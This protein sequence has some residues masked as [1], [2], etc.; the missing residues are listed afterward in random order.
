[1]HTIS[2]F[3]TSCQVICSLKQTH[4][5]SL[6]ETLTKAK[7]HFF[8]NSRGHWTNLY[9]TAGSDN[10]ISLFHASQQFFTGFIV[11]VVKRRVGNNTLHV[12]L[13][14]LQTQPGIHGEWETRAQ[15]SDSALTLSLSERPD[16]FNFVQTCFC[17]FSSSCAFSFSCV[18][19]S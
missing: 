17:F 2:N 15:S 5:N 16:N 1:M 14:C 8:E 9:L 4:I 12:R 11:D 7:K 10:R 19:S 18:S 3:P 6:L 13:P